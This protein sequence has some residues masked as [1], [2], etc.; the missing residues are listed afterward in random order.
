MKASG[1][2]SSCDTE[3]VGVSTSSQSCP[4]RGCSVHPSTRSPEDVLEDRPGEGQSGEQAWLSQVHVSCVLG[5]GEVV[6]SRNKLSRN[7]PSFSAVR[8]GAPCAMEISPVPEGC[9]GPLWMPY[10]QCIL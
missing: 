9:C 10:I 2:V 7:P 8:S 3:E 1:K 6:P 4:A 5:D